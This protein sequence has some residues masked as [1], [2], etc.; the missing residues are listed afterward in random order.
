MPPVASRPPGAALGP[1]ASYSFDGSFITRGPYR[2]PFPEIDPVNN[3]RPLHPL[4]YQ[5]LV[6]LP[7][8]EDAHHFDVNRVPEHNF[9]PCG[10]QP[11]RECE[12]TPQE[13]LRHMTRP[14]QTCYQCHEDQLASCF[15]HH[16][17]GVERTKSWLCV[18]CAHSAKRDNA[19]RP[20]CN[21]TASRLG[22]WLCHAHRD[23]VDGRVEGAVMQAEE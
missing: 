14:M 10:K 3:E 22:S 23:Q 6:E 1:W 21:C 18:D 12:V 9:L 8:S 5:D 16:V 17:A 19:T 4:T 2:W 13:D 11:S 7:C 15:D 20:Q